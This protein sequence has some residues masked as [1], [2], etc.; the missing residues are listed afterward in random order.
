MSEVKSEYEEKVLKAELLPL[1][2][3]IRN[4]AIIE[5]VDAEN[6]KNEPLRLYF[7]RMRGDYIEEIFNINDEYQIVQ[8]RSTCFGK[9]QVLFMGF[10][11]YKSTNQSWCSLEEAILALFAYKFDGINSKAGVLMSRML[12]IDTK[13]EAK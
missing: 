5:R 7:D 9:T 2:M 8:Y 4:Y 12:Q 13:E 11:N 1:S 3:K 6:K 10:L